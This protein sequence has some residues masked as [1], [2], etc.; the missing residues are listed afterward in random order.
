MADNEKTGANRAQVSATSG[1]ET[2][3][4]DPGPTPR[5]EKG[6][7]IAGPANPLFNDPEFARA[8][9]NKRWRQS[10]LAAQ[11]GLQRA[12]EET[13]LLATTPTQAWGVVIE[14]LTSEIMKNAGTRQATNNARLVGQSTGYLRERSEHL[15]AHADF[16]QADLV[17]QMFREKY[18]GD[19]ERALKE[20]AK[21]RADPQGWLR[22]ADR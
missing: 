14:R 19:D 20:A 7:F 11:D 12:V 8:A 6:R 13:G 5:D 18:P 3:K 1:G 16:G 22:D 21:Y 4:R 10:E 15:H 9:I 2:Q 17:L